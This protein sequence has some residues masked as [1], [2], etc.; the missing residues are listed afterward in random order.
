MDN[1]STQF[2]IN[3]LLINYTK[4]TAKIH[5]VDSITFNEDADWQSIISSV[6][7]GDSV[8]LIILSMGPQF[9]VKKIAAYLIYDSAK[10]RRLLK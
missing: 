1:T 4:S 3:V 7:P 2:L 10:R 6:Q 8:E 9:L 5:S